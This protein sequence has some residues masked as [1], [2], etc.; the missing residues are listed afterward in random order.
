[1]DYNTMLQKVKELITEKLDLIVPN[2]AHITKGKLSKDFYLDAIYTDIMALGYNFGD[3]NNATK[4][5]YELQSTV[6]GE[7]NEFYNSTL[8]RVTETAKQYP[9]LVNVFSVFHKLSQNSV[10]FDEVI[11]NV[12]IELEK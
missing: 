9:Q 6:Y 8:I 11:D 7:T 5:I 10:P 12:K 3:V 2:D 4:D 1:M